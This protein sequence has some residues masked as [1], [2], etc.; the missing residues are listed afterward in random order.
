MGGGTTRRLHKKAGKL[1]AASRLKER[2]RFGDGIFT[3]NDTPFA[4][5]KMLSFDRSSH[6][7]DRPCPAQFDIS[8]RSSPHRAELG[9]MS[10][11]VPDE[12]RMVESVMD[13]ACT[14]VTSE[15]IGRT[16]T[17]PSLARGLPRTA[18]CAQDAV[19]PPRRRA[20]ARV[21]R[22]SASAFHHSPRQIAAR[23]CDLC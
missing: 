14:V 16:T 18:R 12:S 8:T 13:T 17:Y 1:Q 10:S 7:G 19:I 23:I 3:S 5:E 11:L 20:Q 4:S 9:G 6:H 21:A 22:I 15:E 2:F